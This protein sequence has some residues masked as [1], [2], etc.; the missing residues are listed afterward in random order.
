MTSFLKGKSDARETVKAQEERVVAEIVDDVKVGQPKLVII[1]AWVTQPNGWTL[2]RTLEDY[3]FSQRALT[4][5]EP[6]GMFDGCAV[7]KRRSQQ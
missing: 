2:A 4:G 5:Y 1:E 3:R 7:W 6:M